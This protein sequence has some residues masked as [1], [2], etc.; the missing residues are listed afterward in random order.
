MCV[1]VFWEPL[2]TYLSLLTVDPFIVGLV[3]W[4]IIEWKIWEGEVKRKDVFSLF[5]L[6]W[7]IGEKIGGSRCFPFEGGKGKLQQQD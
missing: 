1:C 5:S 2:A 4:K 7:K 6:Q 3:G